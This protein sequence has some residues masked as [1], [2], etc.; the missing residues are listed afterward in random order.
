MIT[1]ALSTLV[2][3]TPI[4]SAAG[5]STH[6]R[7]VGST[8]TVWFGDVTTDGCTVT[9]TD[10]KQHTFVQPLAVCA[11]DAAAKAGGFTYDVKDF[12]G[13][14]GLFL[15]RIA[16]DTGASDFSTFW[17]YD[18]NGAAASQGISSKIINNGDSVYFHFE[19]PSADPNKRAVNDGIVYLK[20]QQQS[21]GQIS[22]FTGVSGWAAMTLAAAG[23]DPSTVK[24]GNAS[25]LAYL[26][27]NPPTASSAATDWER[28]ILAITASDKSPYNF[29][30]VNYVQ[31]LESYHNNSQIGVTTQ[32]NDDVFG[33]LALVSAGSGASM[34]TK[35]DALKFILAH[36]GTDGGFSWSTTGTSDVDDTAAALQALIAA[37]NAGM[38]A[39]G[40]STAITN[41]QNYILAAKN[42]DGGFPSTK[43]DTSNTS[44]TSWAVMA[45]TAAGDTG[46]DITNADAYMR[47][48]QEENGSF[49]WQPSAAGE[50][51]TTSY[52]TLALTGKYWPV[53]IFAGVTPTPSQTATPTPSPTATPTVTPTPTPSVT[54]S[55]SPTPSPTITPN[56][57]QHGGIAE[58]LKREQE[59]IREQQ[60]QLFERIHAQI[61]K[62]L[63][64]ISKLFSAFF[65]HK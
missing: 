9:D 42:T 45:L 50:T 65:M 21:N 38:N 48:N 51:F 35:Q 15:Q 17:S 40:L 18:I 2:Y 30:G 23:V 13:S 49:K 20:S 14:L 24:S 37:K 61:Q 28:G 46:A 27:G 47:G 16:Q 55:G 12:G 10:N 60:R 1:F 11:L 5:V 7:I 44:T 26:M 29:G 43:A 8:H 58:I 54:P 56:P 64:R 41:A 57:H 6:V 63:D 3:Y 34:Q 62:E 33:L 25:L 53:K 52:A 19:D 22:S 36:Q 39:T 59:R 32:I 4:A 31:T